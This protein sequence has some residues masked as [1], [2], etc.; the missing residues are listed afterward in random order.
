MTTYYKPKL[1]VMKKMYLLLL[2]ICNVWVFSACTDK[3]NGEQEKPGMPINGLSV[4]SEATV[5]ED[6]NVFGTGFTEASEL[7]VKNEK[8][9]MTKLTVKSRNENG[10]VVTIPATLTAGTYKLVLKQG[11][12]WEL[13]EIKLLASL[14]LKN[15]KMPD[16]IERGAVL[17]IEGEGFVN[18]CKMYLESEAGDKTELEILKYLENGGGLELRIPDD[19]KTGTYFLL[20]VIPEVQEWNISNLDIMAQQRLKKVV[21]SNMRMGRTVTYSI[22]YDEQNRVSTIVKKENSDDPVSYSLV[23]TE[24]GLEIKDGNALDVTYTLTEGHIDFFSFTTKWG[25][26]FEGNWRYEEGYLKSIDALELEFDD[27]VDGNINLW[28]MYTYDANSLVNS[29]RQDVFVYVFTYSFRQDGITP[30]VEI[31]FLAGFAGKR[32]AHLPSAFYYEEEKATYE[33]Q[34]EYVNKV[35]FTGLKDIESVYEFEYE[36]QP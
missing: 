30:E 6:L 13:Q 35:T 19:M 32:T 16:Y 15:L 34:G 31:P 23:Y 8:G 22:Q 21:I 7:Y 3:E 36:L 14:P 4:T 28:D 20:Y 12:E 2:V 25:D 26:F 18:T 11:D 27:V 1:I 9:E 29:F 24:N 10:L 33:T 17:V 5:G